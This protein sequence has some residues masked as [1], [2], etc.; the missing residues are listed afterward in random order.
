[1][2]KTPRRP[3]QQSA[4][5]QKVIGKVLARI[6]GQADTIPVNFYEGTRV[7]KIGGHFTIGPYNCTVVKIIKSTKPKTNERRKR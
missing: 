7:P 4:R 2:A 6:D 5:K 1:M 3:F